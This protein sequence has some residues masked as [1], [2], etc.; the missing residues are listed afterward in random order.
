[1][2]APDRRALRAARTEGI[3]VSTKH[4]WVDKRSKDIPG[5]GVDIFQVCSNCGV[6]RRKNMAIFGKWNSSLTRD[7]GFIP[8][9]GYDFGYVG[10]DCDENTAELVMLA[11]RAFFFT[12]DDEFTRIITGLV[13]LKAFRIL[14]FHLSRTTKPR[15]AIILLTATLPVKSELSHRDQCER[16][17]AKSYP[18]LYLSYV[19]SLP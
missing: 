12:S 2:Q 5:I 8:G 9:Y 19:D 7:D 4:I 16:D 1:M 15:A 13:A 17:L 11:S 10:P 3:A 18:D 6:H 14:D